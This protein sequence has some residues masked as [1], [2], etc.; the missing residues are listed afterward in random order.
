MKNSFADRVRKAGQ[1]FRARGAT[2][3]SGGLAEAIGIQAYKEK[4]L[5]Y[6]AIYDLVKSGEFKRVGKHTFTYVGPVNAKPQKR[7]VMWNYFRMRMKCGAAVTIEELQ[8]AAGASQKYVEEWLAFLVGAGFAKRLG[9]GRFQLLKDP[10]E[11]P[12]DGR[13]AVKLRDM[14]NRRREEVMA[15]LKEIRRMVLQAEGMMGEL[16]E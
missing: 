8:A 4:K 2:F 1:E 16:S 3:T 15:I 7:K 5:V 9:D 13:K 14:R 12:A 11:M 10:V 6:N